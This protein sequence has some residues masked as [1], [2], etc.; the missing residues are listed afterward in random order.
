MLTTLAP[1]VLGLALNGPA[2][3][4]N[5]LSNDALC[6]GKTMMIDISRCSATSSR[7][8]NARLDRPLAEILTVVEAQQ[9]QALDRAQR[10][11]KRYTAEP[12]ALPN[13]SSGLASV[14]AYLPCIDAEPR[15]RVD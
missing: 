3:E 6:W 4:R 12:P 9:R 5:I 1:I 15:H 10:L 7:E 2:G 13:S 14:P 8:A 11:W